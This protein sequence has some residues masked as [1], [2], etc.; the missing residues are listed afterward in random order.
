VIIEWSFGFFNPSLRN[1]QGRID[2]R[3][4]FGHCEA[5]GYTEDQT[6]L[7]LDPQGI[8]LRMRVMHRH[9]DVMDQLEARYALCDLILTMPAADPAFRFP[10]H[11]PLTCASICGNLVGIRALL[12]SDLRRKLQANGARISHEA[13]KGRSNG[14]SGA[15]A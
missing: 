2:P 5:W 15:A 1:L 3:V 12:P 13:T 4:W 10:L 11:G 9:D 8:G 6:W 14:Q 7:F